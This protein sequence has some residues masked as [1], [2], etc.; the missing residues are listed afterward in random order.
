MQNPALINGQKYPIASEGDRLLWNIEDVEVVPPEVWTEWVEMGHTRHKHP[1]GYFFSPGFDPTSGELR[2]APYYH[3]LNINQLTTGYGYFF[4]AAGPSDTI[5]YDNANA[6]GFTADDNVTVTLTIAAQDNRILVVG[7]SNRHATNAD[8][9][10]TVTCAGVQMTRRGKTD[11][12]TEVNS[13]WVLANPSTGADIP[14]VATWSSQQNNGCVIGAVSFYGCDV[15]DSIRTVVAATGTGTTAEVPIASAVND[16]VVANLLAAGNVTAAEDDEDERWYAIDGG[17]KVR[18]AGSTQAGAASVPM[19]WTLSG[20]VD[21]IVLALSIRPLQN[22]RI[23]Y[24]ADG[25]KIFK[26][27]YDSQ[28]GITEVVAESGTA[29]SATASTLVD[30]APAWGDDDFNNNLIKITGGTGAGQRRVI[31]DTT[32]AGD[33]LAIAPDWDVTPDA[34]STYEIYA[35]VYV[36]SGAAGRPVFANSKWYVP[37]GS[38]VNVRRLDT[39]GATVDTWADAGFK[40]LHMANY[41][42]GVQAAVARAYSTNLIDLNYDTGNLSS[43]A[44]DDF[45]IGDASTAITDLHEMN[46]ELIISKEDTFYQMDQEGTS[47]PRGTF[48]N[49]AFTDSENGKGTKVWA[50]RVLYPSVQGLD[51]YIVG[52][53]VRGVGLNQIKG[54]RESTWPAVGVTPFARRHAWVEAVGH[55]AYIGM[56]Y[57]EMTALIHGRLREAGDPVGMEM[58]YNQFHDIPLT[59]GGYIDSQQNLWLKGASAQEDTRDIRVIELDDHGGLSKP[60]RR[61]LASATLTHIG[62]ETDWG[63][64]FSEKQARH[65]TVEL[66]QW[67]S[68]ASLQMYLLRNDATAVAVGDAMT[69]DGVYER[70]LT[71]GTNDRLYR[72]RVILVVT[73]NGNYTPLSLDPRIKIVGAHVRSPAIIKAVVETDGDEPKGKTA[74]DVFEELSRLQDQG[75][76]VVVEPDQMAAGIDPDD[77]DVAGAISFNAGIFR[78]NDVRWKG[79]DDKVGYGVEVGMRRWVIA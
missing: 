56:N 8:P 1:G 20:S 76:I 60:L 31:T 3:A 50:D 7:V 54:F 42:Q 35:S 52:D 28:Q 64:P 45:K 72:G 44:G 40:A 30:A 79:D 68:N 36:A 53:K 78:V 61:G 13:M 59:K 47:K 10:D 33:V 2:L 75:E 67:D 5:T 23:I 49:R 66:S 55:N 74:K 62:P 46:G 37:M 65:L 69:A 32:D 48:R 34:T 39:V 17:N 4:E 58:V 22:Q 27:T 15:N 29:D 43:W 19:K 14:I 12:G 18:G 63:A 9:P 16:I 24:C 51:R 73:T 6:S 41:Q 11:T 25:D 21:W 71:V 57:G 38:G 26:L 77:P 70:A